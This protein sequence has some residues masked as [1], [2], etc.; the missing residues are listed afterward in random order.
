MSLEDLLDRLVYL[1]PETGLSDNRYRTYNPFIPGYN[2]VDPLG[3]AGGSSNPRGYA[4]QNPISFNDP[5]G[6]AGHSGGPPQPP[7]PTPPIPL[8]PSIAPSQPVAP[9]PNSPEECK[10]GC[11]IQY[12]NACH[13]ALS[14]YVNDTSCQ[15][16]LKSRSRLDCEIG[17]AS[18]YAGQQIMARKNFEQC[19]SRCK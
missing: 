3:P 19:L 18:I 13:S 7:R 9:A 16:K 10:Y 1:D 12:E 2:Q 15:T 5:T 8:P 14:D 4:N 17:S 11:T 6:L